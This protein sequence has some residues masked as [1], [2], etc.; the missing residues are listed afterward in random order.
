[1]D[2]G[3]NIHLLADFGQYAV[4]NTIAQAILNKNFPESKVICSYSGAQKGYVVPAAVFMKM[5]LD[6]FAPGSIHICNISLRAEDAPIFLAT[7][8]NDGWILAPDN[9][10]L[11]LIV[12]NEDA[13]FYRLEV[14]TTLFDPFEQIFIPAVKTLV[15]ADMSQIPFPVKEMPKKASFVVPTLQGNS[16][17]LGV[18]CNTADGSAIFNLKK[19]EFNRVRDN[20]PF[21]FRLPTV[22]QEISRIHAHVNEVP[23]GLPVAF[24]GP[25]DFLQI[26]F[27]GGSAKQYLGL[28]EQKTILLEFNPYLAL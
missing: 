24:F 1:M 2:R 23:L 22:D 25:G 11:P 16:M 8:W 13:V 17:R 28:Y 5:V 6:S 15:G 10:L 9:G 12:D 18:L 26:A 19:D 21:R 7:P 3:K 27:N 20:R 4:E 14:P